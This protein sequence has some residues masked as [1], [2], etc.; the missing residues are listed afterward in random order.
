MLGSA[1]VCQHLLSVVAPLVYILCVIL[2]YN[3]ACMHIRLEHR[4][5]GKIFGAFR[6]EVDSPTLCELWHLQDHEKQ[7]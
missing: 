2:L 3:I 5:K 7:V 4:D 6:D 1:A